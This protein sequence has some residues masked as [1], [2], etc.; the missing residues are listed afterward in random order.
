ML[1]TLAPTVVWAVILMA[2]AIAFS[3]YQA[4]G[5]RIAIRKTELTPLGADRSAPGQVRNLAPAKTTDAARIEQQRRLE[6][7]TRERVNLPKD[8]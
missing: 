7:E 8:K 6:Q 5:P 2:G 1:A 3:T 4:F